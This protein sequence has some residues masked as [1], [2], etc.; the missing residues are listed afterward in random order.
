MAPPAFYMPIQGKDRAVDR[1]FT[2]PL[3]LLLMVLI[4]LFVV[5]LPLILGFLFNGLS[6]RGLTV[7][8]AAVW[9]CITVP[10]APVFMLKFGRLE[11]Y[12]H[13][14]IHY[15]ADD[16]RRKRFRPAR[17]RQKAWDTV[18]AFVFSP[19]L[20]VILFLLLVLIINVVLVLHWD[21]F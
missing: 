17:S 21:S 16:G 5:F 14:V 19:F 6:F 20:L 12:E 2:T 8:G 18:K 7:G 4:P 1:R 13:P 15:R 3:R 11:L 9:L 10:L